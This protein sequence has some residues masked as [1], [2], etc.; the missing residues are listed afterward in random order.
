M[1]A[2]LDAATLSA[3]Y[4]EAGLCVLCSGASIPRACAAHKAV[5]A[6]K[7]HLPGAGF[8]QLEMCVTS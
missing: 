7:E 2:F 3:F 1:Q 8:V 6:G 4:S 5:I